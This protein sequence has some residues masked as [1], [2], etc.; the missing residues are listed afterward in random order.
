LVSAHVAATT[1]RAVVG[2]ETLPGSVANQDFLVRLADGAA[3]VL[4]AGPGSEMAA[5]AWA[6][7]RLSEVGLPVPAVVGVDLASGLG[8]AVLILGFV[9]GSP[10]ESP[11]VAFQAGQCMRR[12]HAEELPGWGALV[13][14]DSTGAASAGGAFDSWPEAVLAEL[15]GLPEL[16]D[17]A[18]LDAELAAAARACVECDALLGYDGPAVLLHRDLKPA[19]L[20]GVDDGRRLSAIIDWGDAHVGDPTADL[21]R[22]SMAGPVI[23]DAFLAGYGR[24]TS[25]DL[26]ELL[27]RYRVLWDVTA[28]S[29]ELGAGG[30]W[31]DVY[32]SR[33]R[34]DTRLLTS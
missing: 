23:T 28:L 18:V 32:R 10:S 4:K 20:F 17:A 25:A 9:P 14:D 3:V 31:F 30:D 26:A 16:V 12:V 33:L 8:T 29:Y 1:G 7:R 21:A 11:A 15:A 24:E 5:E 13:V 22:L 34:S 2:A 19:H 6:C 27:A